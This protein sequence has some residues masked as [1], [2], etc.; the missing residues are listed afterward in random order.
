MMVRMLLVS[1]LA[2][3]YLTLAQ[4][5]KDGWRARSTETYQGAT[6]QGIPKSSLDSK[7]Q[8]A[9]KPDLTLSAAQQTQAKSFKVNNAAHPVNND[10]WVYDASTHLLEDYDH[11][12]YYYIFSVTFDVDT[13]YAHADLYARLYLGDGEIYREYH[14]TSV[15]HIDDNEGND[16]F[17]V[18][19]ELLSGYQ[20]WDY[21]VLI[22][23]YE[24]GSDHLVAVYDNLD[25]ADLSYLPLESY[26]YEYRPSHAP[27]TSRNREHGG[28]I[29][30]IMLLAGVC[31]L[32]RRRTAANA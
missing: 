8:I 10:F 14:T 15:F 16:E 27:Q 32:W 4:T 2:L 12:N 30:Y 1:L 21:D 25:D 28:S 11:D 3:P 20:S 23:V 7:T 29:A 17:E 26:D 24:A 13:I 22:E 5:E 18:E 6:K 31:M 9:A 19:T